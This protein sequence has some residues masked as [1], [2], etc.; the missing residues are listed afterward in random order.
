MRSTYMRSTA[1]RFVILFVCALSLAFAISSCRG[2]TSEK[3]PVH[4]N[5]N[6][7]TQHKYKAYRE[8]EFFA[9]K[10][11]MRPAV[12]GAV[13]RGKLKDD[14]HF[15]RGLV[16]DDMA[17]TLPKEV[18]LTME[19]LNRGR[20]RFGIYCAPCHGLAGGGDGMVGRRIG[21]QSAPK[22]NMHRPEMY[23]YP[24]GYFFNVMTNGLARMRP[25]RDKLSEAD[26]WAVAAY[27]RALLV[28]QDSEGTWITKAALGK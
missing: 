1:M 25:Y 18:P 28:S 22:L 10:R 17:T 11:D 16:N 3:P 7:D 15:Y 8:S 5:L 6:M 9:D 26:R 24:I 14:D 19:T 13:A 2:W 20:D 23:Q 21:I 12:E 4:P 27:V